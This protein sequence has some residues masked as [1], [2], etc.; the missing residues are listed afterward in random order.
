MAKSL[1]G[2]DRLEIQYEM[3]TEEYKGSNLDIQFYC[4]IKLIK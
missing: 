2:Q 1:Y 4:L 3:E